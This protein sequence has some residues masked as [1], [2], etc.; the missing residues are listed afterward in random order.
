MRGSLETANPAGTRVAGRGM[1]RSRCCASAAHL[2]VA[3]LVLAFAWPAAA[4]T[5]P[6]RRTLK[7]LLDESA[8]LTYLRARQPAEGAW[9]LGLSV[10]GQSH[11]SMFT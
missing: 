1:G 8:S 6:S 3:A 10:D 11:C 7:E 5:S 9:W 4:S 2:L